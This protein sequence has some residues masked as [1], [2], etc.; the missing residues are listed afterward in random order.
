[1]KC[2]RCN[3][4]PCNC[5]DEICILCGNCLDFAESIDG[6]DLTLTDPPYKHA[7]MDGGG[8]ASERKF[9]AGGALD[10]LNN[11]DVQ[12]YEAVLI[13]HAKMLIAFH[14]RD[15]IGDY[16][17]LASRHGRKYDL[18]AWHKTNA[19]P[20]TANTWKS[21]IEYIALVWQSKPGWKQLNQI[22]HSKCFS[23]PIC[24]DK[25]H[26]AC[27]PIPLI[28][29]YIA[30]LDAKKIFDPFMGSGTTLVAAKQ[31]GRKAIGIEIEEKYCEIAA[32]RLANEPRP[33]F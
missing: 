9:Y 23:S 1:M 18:H 13:N 5:G 2:Y 31:L 22:M 4:W 26:P 19:I 29:K 12:Q 20:F 7:H 8:F 25:H 30:V 15:L 21:D 33:L 32:N 10:G 14:S 11:F 17:S 3:L 6:C 28:A 27:K 24:T 16:A